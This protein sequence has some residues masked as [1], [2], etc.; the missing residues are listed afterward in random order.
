MS[1][2]FSH[3]LI[4]GL[5]NRPEFPAADS[6]SHYC[7]STNTILRGRLELSSF[8]LA[9]YTSDIGLFPSTSIDIANLQASPTFY[10]Q[11]PSYAFDGSEIRHFLFGPNGLTEEPVEE[12]LLWSGPNIGLFSNTSASLEIQQAPPALYQQLPL[13]GF[14]CQL[15]CGKTFKRDADRARHENSRVHRIVQGHHLCPITGCRKSQGIGFSR[16]DKVTEHLW[17]KHA[18]LG[19]KKREQ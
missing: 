1:F 2:F 19:Y 4:S 13:P 7:P 6:N 14:P 8:W 16:S 11:L 3:L 12:A 9:F 5:P 18:D 10:E 17:K 15:G